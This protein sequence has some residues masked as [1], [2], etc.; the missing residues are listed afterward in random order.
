LPVDAGPDPTISQFCRRQPGGRRQ[1]SLGITCSKA[2]S[3]AARRPLPSYRSAT[4]TS[5]T[6]AA[7]QRRHAPQP[8]GATT[9][10]DRPA[11]HGRRSTTE[12]ACAG[13]PT[14]AA[15]ARPRPATSRPRPRGKAARNNVEMTQS[16]GRTPDRE[17]GRVRGLPRSF[18][19]CGNRERARLPRVT[20]I[21]HAVDD[22]SSRA[23]A[24]LPP[25]PADERRAL[26]EG[27]RQ[28]MP[29]AATSATLTEGD[30]SAV[31]FASRGEHGS[32]RVCGSTTRCPI[33]HV[34]AGQEGLAAAGTGVG[35]AP[36][37][38]AP[39]FA[40]PAAT[41]PVTDSRDT[42]RKRR[43][44]TSHGCGHT[45]CTHDAFTLSPFQGRTGRTRS[46]A[47]AVRSSP[48][49]PGRAMI[50][51][52]SARATWFSSEKFRNESRRYPRTR[53]RAM[54]QSS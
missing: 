5:A 2:G 45:P 52:G 50:T 9:R 54:S 16:C 11:H 30:R 7:G 44:V 1:R 35:R 53:Q 10:R 25:R 13:R 41:N 38:N 3:C 46:N 37:S 33:A 20:R 26:R 34:C 51:T 6:S 42:T 32:P 12:A 22:L 48:A 39:S 36:G 8:S 18:S 21:P 4:S 43:R 49:Q 14:A 19:H 31:R 15:P 27:R 47:S 29:M 28:L 40:S 23:Q 17:R 24:G